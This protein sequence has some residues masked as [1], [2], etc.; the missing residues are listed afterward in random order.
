MTAAELLSVAAFLAGRHAQ[1]FPSF[2]SERTGAPVVSYCRIS[3][4]AIRTREPIVEPDALIILDPTLMSQ[5]SL[6]A[7][8]RDDGYVLVNT[9]RDIRELGLGELTGRL[10]PERLLAVPATELAWEHIGRPI[11]NV[12]LLGGFAAIT[13]L[14]PIGA[15]VGAIH[16]RFSD[17]IAD[18]N[19]AAANAAYVFVTRQLEELT[20]AAPA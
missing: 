17:K 15:V 1:A 14:L 11:P 3:D 16:D 20:G 10:Q 7:G 13:G 18:G 5:V 9:S 19:V 6:L 8:L 2:G 4:E 12:V